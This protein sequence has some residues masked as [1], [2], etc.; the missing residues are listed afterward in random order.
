MALIVMCSRCGFELRRIEAEDSSLSA[1]TPLLM[2]VSRRYGSKCP[3]CSKILNL[4]PVSIEVKMAGSP[5]PKP[6]WLGIK[7]TRASK[8]TRVLPLMKFS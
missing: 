7:P 3:N 4:K 8:A 1:K 6:S 2:D 5:L